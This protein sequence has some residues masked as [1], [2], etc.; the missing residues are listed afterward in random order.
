V[1]N[2]HVALLNAINDSDSVP[3]SAYFE[4]A[5]EWFGSKN[6]AYLSGETICIKDISNILLPNLQEMIDSPTSSALFFFISEACARGNTPIINLL[7]STLAQLEEQ[8]DDSS[9]TSTFQL[10]C[11]YFMIEAA[12]NAQDKICSLLVPYCDFQ[13]LTM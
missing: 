6:N 10:C 7:I 4:N 3:L 11:E 8:H 9:A 5:A 13:A 2:G 1:K 12:A